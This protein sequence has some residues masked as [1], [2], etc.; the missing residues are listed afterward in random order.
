ML[1]VRT[2]LFT[3]GNNWRMIQKARDLQADAIILDL[4]DAVPMAEKET[5]R[6]F[7]RDGIPLIKSSGNQTFVRVNALTTGLTQ[8]DLFYSVQETLDGVILSKTESTAD[9]QQI[10]EMLDK[11]EKENGLPLGSTS[12]IPLL[13]TARGVM[14]AEKIAPASGRI[15]GLCFG[16]LDFTRNMGTTQSRDGTEIFY[17]R[18]KI[19]LVANAYNIQPIDT[20]WFNLADAEGLDRDAGLARRL[21]F[22]GKL[23]IHP[24][25]IERV[26]QIF[27]PSE[28]DVAY[29]ETVVKAFKEAERQGIGAVSLHGKMIDVASF[30]QAEALLKYAHLIAE[31]GAKKKQTLF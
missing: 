29:A 28:G 3:P 21:G 20:P 14:N 4:E 26:N 12:L 10:G 23:L 8:E 11:L 27:S 7:V 22:K 2:L 25:Q 17:A 16:A 24:E 15:I 6:I 19:A 31:K 30:H 1:L 5:A 13:E 18:S 9:I